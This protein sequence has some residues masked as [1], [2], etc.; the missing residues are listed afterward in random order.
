MRS[1]IESKKA[2]QRFSVSRFNNFLKQ[3]REQEP[4]F[5]SDNI[6]LNSDS[7]QC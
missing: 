6:L 3:R 7:A 4:E 1:G 5:D 2:Q